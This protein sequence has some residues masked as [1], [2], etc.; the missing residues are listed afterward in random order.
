[1][2]GSL[3][4]I[5]VSIS[6]NWN[7]SFVLQ[8]KK[9]RSYFTNFLRVISLY[10]FSVFSVSSVGE[11]RL[12]KELSRDVQSHEVRVIVHDSDVLST[13]NTF[14]MD[15]VFAVNSKFWPLVYYIHSPLGI[16]NTDI[17]KYILIP[18]DIV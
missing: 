17:S 14:V 6:T 15:L 4:N 13:A 9:K 1:M 12:E 8:K 5:K 3:P 7:T 16:S 11:I 2:C 18:K 10:S